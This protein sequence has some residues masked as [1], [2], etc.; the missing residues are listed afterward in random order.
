M[1]HDAASLNKL[2]RHLAMSN[3]T[4]LYIMLKIC[5]NKTVY[6]VDCD[7]K[8]TIDYNIFIISIVLMC[9][10][11]VQLVATTWGMADF[12]CQVLGENSHVE[13]CGL[14]RKLPASLSLQLKLHSNFHNNVHVVLGCAVRR[15]VK[16]VQMFPPYPDLSTQAVICYIPSCIG[17]KLQTFYWPCR[18]N[19]CLNTKD[20]WIERLERINCFMCVRFC[21]HMVC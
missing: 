4:I 16:I 17:W 6:T 15:A 10:L 3:L 9:W 8:F 20:G 2:L 11:R 18:L 1:Q 5:R 19:M 12:P 14:I 21:V 7:L 13:T